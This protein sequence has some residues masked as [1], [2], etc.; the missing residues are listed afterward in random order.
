MTKTITLLENYGS[1]GK[2]KSVLRLLYKDNVDSKKFLIRR[3]AII[4]GIISFCIIGITLIALL[5]A[6]CFGPR[7][8]LYQENCSRRSC[9]NNFNLKC[10]NSTCNCDTGYI[11]IDKCTLK[12]KYLESCHSTS[13]CGDNKNLI[14]LDGVCKCND[15]IQYWTGSTCS[16]KSTYQQVCYSNNQCLTSQMLYC[17]ISTLLCLCD[18]STRFW[19]QSSCFPQRTINQRCDSNSQCL[20][21]QNL[22]CLN[23]QCK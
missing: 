9:I 5:A 7:K 19:Y 4:L 11:Y 18:T 15:A 14:C 13:Y 23:G 20:S 1:N 2:L 6:V 21:S 8:G 10:I 16:S 12:K 22:C 3:G 17:N